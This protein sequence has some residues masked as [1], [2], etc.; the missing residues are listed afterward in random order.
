LATG[1]GI[2]LDQRR[3]PSGGAVIASSAGTT[4]AAHALE[5][6]PLAADAIA[7]ALVEHKAPERAR[8]DASSGTLEWTDS[9][10]MMS[11]EDCCRSEKD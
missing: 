5:G 11:M 3:G 8:D 4:A 9:N 10:E 6:P 7:T 1:G 2:A